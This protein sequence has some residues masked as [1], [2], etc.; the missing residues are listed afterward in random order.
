MAAIRKNKGK[1]P[2]RKEIINDP[3]SF[4]NREGLG[5]DRLFDGLTA[6]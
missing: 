4:S 3:L 5:L 6:R 1:F 2:A